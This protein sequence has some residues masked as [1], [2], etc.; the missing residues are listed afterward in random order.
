RHRIE[1]AQVL[2]PDDVNRFAE[3]DVIPSM[4]PIHCTQDIVAADANWGARARLAYAWSTL[5]STGAVLAFGSDAPV[6]TPSMMEGLY[7]AVARRRPDGYPGPDG[8]YP[9]EKLT[10][11]EAVYAYTMGAAFAGG[12]ES[13]KGSLTAGKLADL[14]VLDRDIFTVEAEEVLATNV[15]ATMVG[16]EVVYGEL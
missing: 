2:H 9:E 1:H 14:T 3:L 15:S 13:I 7:A 12:E 11:Q 16:G 8:W 4:Q 10:M 5:L 6:E